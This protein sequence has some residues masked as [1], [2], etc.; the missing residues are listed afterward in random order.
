MEII[1]NR[2]KWYR[3][4][5]QVERDLYYLRAR[6]TFQRSYDTCFKRRV[7]VNCGS[8]YSIASQGLNYPCKSHPGNMLTFPHLH[9][10]CCGIR[11][12]RERPSGV[13]GC[14]PSHHWDGIEDS[15]RRVGGHNLENC[16]L[17]PLPI[18]FVLDNSTMLCNDTTQVNDILEMEEKLPKIMEEEEDEFH[19]EP[20]REKEIVWTKGEVLDKLKKMTD[21]NNN[22]RALRFEQTI[23]VKIYRCK[24]DTSQ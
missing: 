4:V 10:S 16:L 6:D 7:C 15:T 1:Q 21:L 19:F 24:R 3:R 23:L 2:A 17:L 12:N 5:G 18:L 11:P 20:T 8:Y 9:W 13:I 14:T 22:V